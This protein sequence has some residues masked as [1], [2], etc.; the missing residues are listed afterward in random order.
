M[1]YPLLFER[2]VG[3]KV[4]RVL[5]DGSWDAQVLASYRSGCLSCRVRFT[6]TST[7]SVYILL[8]SSEKEKKK[9]KANSLHKLSLLN[10]GAR[11]QQH[12][13]LGNP[14]HI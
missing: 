10:P 7:G 8:Y 4:A 9:K 5:T 14:A 11:C 3:M 2:V 12:P 6:T 13:K 1:T